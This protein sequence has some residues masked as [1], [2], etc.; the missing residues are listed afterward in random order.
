[1]N[2][3]LQVVCWSV[4]Y[5]AYACRHL[6]N[7][8]GLAQHA[9]HK[10]SCCFRWFAQRL[11]ALRHADDAPLCVLYG[12]HQLQPGAQAPGAVGQGPV[13][14]FNLLRHDGSFFGYRSAAFEL[15]CCA[16]LCCAVLCCAVLCCGA[17]L[18]CAV[19]CCAVLCCAVLCCAV[20]CCA[21]LC[22]AVLCCARQG[23]KQP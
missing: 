10:H 8:Q 13:V 17:V 21:V 18:W 22:C 5:T 14:T 3:L 11:V 16:V 23:L 19:L 12:A 9:Q 15:L 1:M 2:L 4:L 6:S 7:G 20:L